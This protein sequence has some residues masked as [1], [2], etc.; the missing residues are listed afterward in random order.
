MDEIINSL[1]LSLNQGKQFQNKQTNKKQSNKHPTNKKKYTTS[2][3]KEGFTATSDPEN[4]QQRIP[5]F[6]NQYNRIK[7]LKSGS[8]NEFEEL[9]NLQSQYDELIIQY[10]DA[11][12]N[13]ETDGTNYIDRISS[14][15]VYLNKNITI[16]NSDGQMPVVSSGIG[17][18]V[19][20]KGIFKNYADQA[21]FDATAGKNG[22]P[23][24]IMK[25]IKLNNFSSLLSNGTDMKSGQSCGNEG[26]NVY[27]SNVLTDPKVEYARCYYNTNPVDNT[28]TP[29]TTPLEGLYTFDDCKQYAIDNGKQYFSMRGQPDA[30]YKSTCLIGNTNDLT[31]MQQYGDASK[32][33]T[34]EKIWSTE[35]LTDING[36]TKATDHTSV[37][38]NNTG[39]LVFSGSAGEQAF[40]LGTNSSGCEQEFS[41]AE[42]SNCARNDLQHLTNTNLDICKQRAFSNPRAAG[43][44]MNDNGKE[45]WIKSK[46]V[47]V[48][49]ESG[50]TIYTIVKEESQSKCHF[51]MILQIDG[52]LCIY[53]GLDPARYEGGGALWCAMTNGQQK[54]SN[55]AWMAANGKLSAPFL[56]TG[57]NLSIDEWI[58]SDD[59]KLKLIMESS[60]NLVLY[61]CTITNGC[62]MNR[63]ATGITFYGNTDNT[64]ALYQI[65]EMGFPGNLGNVAYIDNNA[66]AHK[67]PVNL[68]GYS[69]TYDSY[70]NFDSPG[71]DIGTSPASNVDDCMN[72]CNN[73][74]ECAGFV[75]VNYDS[76]NKCYLKNSNMYPKTPRVSV[77]N[78]MTYVRR[79]QINN[80]EGDICNKN[81][82]DVDSLKYE[83]YLKGPDMTTNSPFCKDDVISEDDKRNMEDIQNKLNMKGQEIS[84]KIEELYAKD[85]TIFD[86]M[87]VNDDNL[88]KKILMYKS[89][90]MGKK[91]K[92]TGQDLS[93]QGQG[94][95]L[96]EGMQGLDM[97]DVNGMLQDAD[98]RILQENYSYVVWSVLAVGLL[99]ITINLMKANNK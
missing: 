46:I 34:K 99:T 53:K 61:R 44:V 81:I 82:I 36:L 16:N 18:Y 49:D 92:I 89:I 94:Q 25:D 62:S 57:Q 47:K 67:Y 60:G 75:W 6:M 45:C 73:N 43:F 71:N 30:N 10:N 3:L 28:T 48:R 38:L 20:G 65:N 8:S 4:R 64:N 19:T 90:A 5:V 86:K 39:Q 66:T 78:L 58:G 7:S 74:N 69:N 22:C 27:V 17:G 42:S 96:K 56:S 41:I 68:L 31:Q 40:K 29:V 79:P 32:I 1:S 59:G 15:N 87:D 21:T 85:K 93:G 63:G 9:N 37:R 80:V 88:K 95:D 72:A 14:N 55:P 50:R 97:N 35:G 2:S 54:D 77:N 98:I 70:N 76:G 91:T 24:Q 26:T 83:N 84:A 52:N 23:A 33:Y 51:Y 13:V 12:Q 11:Q